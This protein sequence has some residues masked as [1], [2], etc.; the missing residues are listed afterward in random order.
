MTWGGS[1][2]RQW[3]E[4]IEAAE[5]V[6]DARATG[7]IVSGSSIF[8][9]L[10]DGL[11]QNNA[12]FLSDYSLYLVGIDPKPWRNL[13]LQS[14]GLIGEGESAI[15]GLAGEPPLGSDCQGFETRRRRRD[16]HRVRASV[17]TRREVP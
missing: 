2:A 12:D 1:S 10:Y 3:Y 11:Y 9:E 15:T 6:S 17:K 14:T 8:I 4:T 5:S 7:V 16:S 13:R